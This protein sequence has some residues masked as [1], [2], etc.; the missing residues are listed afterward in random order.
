VYAAGKQVMLPAPDLYHLYYGDFT[1]AFGQQTMQLVDHFGANLVG[2][3]WWKINT[4]YYQTVAGVTS[5]ISNNPTNVLKKS[6]NVQTTL[7]A[8]SLTIPDITAAI[9]AAITSGQFAADTNAL[10]MVMFAGYLDFTLPDGTHWIDYWC[11]FHSRFDYFAPGSK[12]AINL[13]Y[14][15]HGDPSSAAANWANCAMHGPGDSANGN[16]GADSI[17]SIYAHEATEIVTNYKGAWFFNHPGTYYY[18]EENADLCA[19]SF[20]PMLSNNTNIVVGGM[21]WLVQQNW[22]PKY[23]CR[24]SLPY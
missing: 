16:W 1:S 21:E 8:G 5:Y 4:A 23:G 6:I 19:W 10:Y 22:V 17:A 13:K 20:E 11:G 15:V 2:S 9:S 14:G 7:L 18:G 12:V 3:D 24:L